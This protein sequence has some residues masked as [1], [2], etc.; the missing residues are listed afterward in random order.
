MT[1]AYNIDCMDYM[2]QL[3]DKYFDLAIVDPP[4]GKGKNISSGG[5]WSAKY[6]KTD[7]TW[8]N[9]I[10]DKEYFDELMRVS[11]SQIIWCAIY[12]QE[13]LYSSRGWIV[14]RK[15]DIPEGFSMSM[16]ELAWSS[17][18]INAK[19]YESLP[20]RGGRWHPAQKPE[21]LYKWL[22]ATYAKPGWKILD[23]HLGSGSIRIACD[24][25]GFEFVG[26]EKDKAIFDKQEE[27]FREYLK[28]PELFDK[29]EY[30]NQ[31]LCS[32]EL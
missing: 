20:V 6:K 16:V 13:Y 2:R 24:K 9:E 12:Y 22:L 11:K 17:F 23:T 10:P 32:F 27:L 3:P 29:Q 7:M 15:K 19:C 21:G 4:N 25:M 26:C 18:D 31:D 28:Q 14:W 5:T 30:I 1:I 8:N